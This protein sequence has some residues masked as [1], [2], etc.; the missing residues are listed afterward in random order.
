MA[1]E[2]HTAHLGLLDEES[3]AVVIRCHL[4]VAA[5]AV[6]APK[7][8]WLHLTG[9]QQQLAEASTLWRTIGHSA[10][11]RLSFKPAAGT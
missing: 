3:T 11:H 10:A 7:Q 1:R 6:I 4:E 2:Q 9:L 8:A 5:P